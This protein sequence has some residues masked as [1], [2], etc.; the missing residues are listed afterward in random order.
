MR[1][2]GYAASIAAFFGVPT[3]PIQKQLLRLEEDGVIVG[4]TLGKVREYELNPRYPFVEPL[5]L[6]LKA[7]FAAYPD[8]VKADLL[9]QRTRPRQPG[10]PL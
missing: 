9:M 10:K 2:T 4:R 7:A 3:N 8:A 1:N 5:K 6:L